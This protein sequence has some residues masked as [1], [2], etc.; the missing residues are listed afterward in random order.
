MA[1]GVEQIETLVI[2]IA[3]GMWT[4]TKCGAG[5]QLLLPLQLATKQWPRRPLARDDRSNAA[6]FCAKD[7][8]SSLEF[9]VLLIVGC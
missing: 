5:C 7:E 3:G 9:C 8:T 4:R 2:V 6:G 1:A